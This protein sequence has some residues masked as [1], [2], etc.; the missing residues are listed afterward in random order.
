[1]ADSNTMPGARRQGPAPAGWNRD[2]AVIVLVHYDDP[3]VERIGWR[4]RRTREGDSMTKP[5]RGG[6][7]AGRDCA[8]FTLGAVPSSVQYDPTPLIGRERELEAIRTA[9]L[10]EPVRLLTLMGPG[11]IGKTRLAVA[12]A[13]AVA[14]AFSD[15]VWF[16]DLAPLHDPAGIDAAIGRALKL[17]ESGTLSPAKQVAAYVKG[18]NLLL[19]LDNFE[20]LLPAAAVR[21]AALLAAAPRVKVLV[22]SREL[23]KLHAE[24]RFVVTGLA[25]PDLGNVD[26]D[27]IVQ[28]P[29]VA[30]F[31][32]HARRIQPELVLTPADARLL[33]AL[34]HRLEGIPLAIQVAA[35][36]SHVLSTAAMLGRL[37]GQALLST[38]E[39]Q[40]APARHLTL[41]H[42]IDWSY[43]LLDAAGQAAFRQLG[44]FVGGWTLDAAEAI[45]HDRKGARPSWATLALLVDKS[46]VQSDALAG[47]DRRYRLLEPI[48]EYALERLR[49]N[50]ELEAARDRHARY[51]LT[52]AEQPKP[53]PWG[54][55]E[56]AWGRRLDA[57]YENVLAALRWAAERRDGDLSLRLAAAMADYWAWRSYLREGRRWL[58][59]A[60]ALSSEA[61]SI[62]RARALVGEGIL[63]TL[64]GE[65]QEAQ[66]LL[67]DA[68]GLAEGLRDAALTGRVLSRLG[69]LAVIR[70]DRNAAGV[71]ERSVA[72]SRAHDPVVTAFALVQLAWAL[73]LLGEGKRADAALAEGLDLTRRTGSARLIARR[74]LDGAQLALKRRDYAGASQRAFE[75]L[76]LARTAGSRRNITHAAMIAALVSGQRGEVERAL[77]LLGAVEAWSDWTGQILSLTHQDPAA[78]AAIHTSAR[79]QLGD[80]AYD[81]VLAEAR[82]L[83]ADQAADLAEATFA[84]AAPSR[85]SN[86]HSAGSD[87][88]RLSLS[89]RER[90]VLRLIGEGLSNKQIASAL[91]ISERTVK[92]HVGSAMNKLGVDN[93]AHAAVAAIQ[94]G[95][96]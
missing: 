52:L 14:P 25:L 4:R 35:V 3:D 69:R 41:R 12:A 80:P 37:R 39:W 54:P 9:L 21:I 15:G 6:G 70:G 10:N 32:E 84:A 40:G 42:S 91:R 53:G 81:A 74:L 19:V 56:G 50:G 67:Q 28:A 31:L 82:T 59:T 7:L 76:R 8:Q 16:V 51:Y 2:F 27:A 73:E 71:L 95:L 78:Y 77:R 38:G 92:Y 94:R 90:A 23:L 13:Q 29:A 22:T 86:G 85:D 57:D 62:I 26:R 11:G 24:H 1:M 61:S 55:T 63:V 45:I 93:R 88:S 83:S 47:D 18:R 30:L 46:L 65:Y 48:R 68:L 33:A 17:G 5:R 87:R 58:A 66:A 79:R 64:L 20:H 36:H 60:R 89:D 44:I 72:E 43:G 75:A 96:L 49:E 34:L